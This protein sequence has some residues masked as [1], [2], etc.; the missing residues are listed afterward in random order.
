[1]APFL[2]SFEMY[3]PVLFRVY[4]N[5]LVIHYNF[6]EETTCKKH[7]GVDHKVMSSLL[8]ITA[9]DRVPV[10]IVVVIFFLYI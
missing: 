2:F 6:I 4:T 5:V 1:M 9:T 8:L 7:L 10:Q 3:N